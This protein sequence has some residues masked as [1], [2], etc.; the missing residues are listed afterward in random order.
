MVGIGW[1]VGKPEATRLY[2]DAH[3]MPAMRCTDVDLHQ[4]GA[5]AV[6]GEAKKAR[7]VSPQF[8]QGHAAV[9][10][11]PDGGS[12]SPARSRL[13]SVFATCLSVAGKQSFRQRDVRADMPARLCAVARSYDASGAYAANMT[14]NAP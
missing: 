12:N 6:V 3:T 1:V 13:R 14:R 10:G 5:C 9:D 4:P 8:R 11:A 7:R 2:V